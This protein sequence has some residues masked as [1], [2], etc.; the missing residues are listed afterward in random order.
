MKTKD[1][2]SSKKL[3]VSPIPYSKIGAVLLVMLAVM[4]YLALF[5]TMRPIRLMIF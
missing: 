4:E 1:E 3:A 5:L 2:T